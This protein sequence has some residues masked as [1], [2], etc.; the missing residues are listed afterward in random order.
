MGKIEIAAYVVE[1]I[2][3]IYIFYVL[4]MAIMSLIPKVYHLFMG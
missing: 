1:L 2:V 3:G 4:Y